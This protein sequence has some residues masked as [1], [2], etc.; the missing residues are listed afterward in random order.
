M[1]DIIS[2]ADMDESL[3]Y[4]LNDTP[5]KEISSQINEHNQRMNQSSPEYDDTPGQDRQNKSNQSQYSDEINEE[6][7]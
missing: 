4:S 1:N 7:T 2:T 3:Y 5:E 6:L